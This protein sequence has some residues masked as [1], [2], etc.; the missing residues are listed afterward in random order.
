MAEPII[1]GI[2]S[3]IGLWVIVSIP[4]YISARSLTSGRVGFGRAMCATL[5]GPLVY[6]SV[7]FISNIILNMTI[8]N[9]SFMII[10]FI[11]SIIAWLGTFKVIFKTGWLTTIGIVVLAIIVFVIGA[12]IF[13][14]LLFAIMPDMPNN[15]LPAPQISV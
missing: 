12:I 11:L 6:A 2:L 4:V 13:S 8:N 10:A 3:L 9:P 15:I 7:F 1:V 14:L 5:L